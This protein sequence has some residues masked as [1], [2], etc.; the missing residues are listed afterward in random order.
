M[1]WVF[2][3]V[4]IILNNNLPAQQILG[5]NLIANPSFENLD[6]CMPSYATT[7][8]FPINGTLHYLPNWYSPN[9]ATPDWFDSCTSANWF[10]VPETYIGFQT[11]RTGRGFAGIMIQPTFREYLESKLLTTLKPLRKYVVNYYINRGYDTYPLFRGCDQLGVNFTKDTFL[12]QGTLPANIIAT[13]VT[14]KFQ[15]FTD[16]SNW[17]LIADTFTAIGNENFVTFGQ[18]LNQALTNVL[19]YNNTLTKAPDISLYYYY[20]DVAVRELIPTY[21]YSKIDTVVFCNEPPILNGRKNLSNYKWND[22]DVNSVRS[23]NNIGLYW[24]ESFDEANYTVYVDSFYVKAIYQYPEIANFIPDSITICKGDSIPINIDYDFGNLEV[25]YLWNTGS[26][27]KKIHIAEEGL[28]TIHI[29]GYCK[30]YKD[31]ITLSHFSIPS[32]VNDTINQSLCIENIYFQFPVPNLNQFKWTLNNTFFD[33]KIITITDTG[34][35]Q[36]IATEPN[37]NNKDTI[38]IYVTAEFCE[39]C[40]QVPNAFSP[41]NDGLNDYLKPF[42]YC[43]FNKFEIQIFNRFGQQVFYALN[44]DEKWDGNFNGKNCDIGVYHYFIK[45]QPKWNEFKEIVLK[46]AIT[47]LR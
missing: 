19:G 8:I 28:Y 27:E 15:Y 40:I 12:Y 5:P 7:S 20:D 4:L 1:K 32:F 26:T 47:L 17:T 16:T 10:Q 11:P 6:S 29:S 35:Y 44:P 9:G 21:K 3:V 34:Q 33:Q 38:N 18:F 43:N 13:C 46:G 31:S 36:L 2:I 39:K 37:C 30:D 14:P 22:D 42:I 41:N 23:V 24:V 45:Y 25:N